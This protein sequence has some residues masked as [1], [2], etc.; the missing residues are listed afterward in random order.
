MKFNKKNKILFVG[1]LLMLFVSY[2]LAIKKTMDE[3]KAHTVNFE[4]KELIKDI[5][6]QLAFLNQKEIHLDTQLRLLNVENSSLQNSLLK[7]LNEASEK[8]KVKIIE[9]N[10]PHIY[11]TERE[12]KETYIFKLEGSYTSIL[13]TI[14]ALENKGSFGAVAHLE[15]EKKKDYR[16]KRTFLQAKIFLE[17]VK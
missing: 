4:R 11:S 10:S 8:H 7:F 12:T 2:R 15:M 9:F 14:H 17:F 6:K 16:T 3:A 1:I 5:P 13:K